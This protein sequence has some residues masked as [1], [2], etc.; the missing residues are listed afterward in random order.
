MEF[1]FFFVF[2]FVVAKS[3]NALAGLKNQMDV[4]KG[5]RKKIRNA[6][7][8]QDGDSGHIFFFKFLFF[9]FLFFL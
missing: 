1:V 9:F 5:N 7:D 6:M 8:K 2:F 4:A 3:S